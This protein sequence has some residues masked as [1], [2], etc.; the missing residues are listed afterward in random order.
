MEVLSEL[1]A[2]IRSMAPEVWAIYIRRQYVV[3]A[4]DLVWAVLCVGLIA[5]MMYVVRL[6]L[7]KKDKADYHHEDRWI[8]VTLVGVLVIAIAAIA[9]PF[10]LTDGIMRL[11]TP[12]YCAIQ[13]LLSAI[14]PTE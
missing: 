12:E 1:L 4:V 5:P 14:T 13:D 9:V 8:L 7:A 2:W 10:L 11:L 6:G 3:A